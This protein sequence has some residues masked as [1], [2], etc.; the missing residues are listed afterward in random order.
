MV[1]LI[2]LKLLK[3]THHSQRLRIIDEAFRPSPA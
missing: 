2:T 1:F 3:G